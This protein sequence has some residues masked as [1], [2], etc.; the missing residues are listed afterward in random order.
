MRLIV[1]A[2]AGMALAACTVENPFTKA[3]APVSENGRFQVAAFSKSENDGANSAVIL[4]TRMG[5]VWVWYGVPAPNDKL[6]YVGRAGAKVI[7]LD[8]QGN[9]IDP[10]PLPDTNDPLGIRDAAKSN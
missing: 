7:T 10:L 5:D 9:V 8:E 3:K 6:R 2:V 1:V 4:D